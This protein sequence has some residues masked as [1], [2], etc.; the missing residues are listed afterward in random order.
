MGTGVFPAV[1]VAEAWPEPT[2]PYCV[3]VKGVEL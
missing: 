2:T 3:E 1:K